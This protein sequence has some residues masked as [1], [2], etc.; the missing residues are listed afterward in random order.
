MKAILEQISAL[1]VS[2]GICLLHNRNTPKF[3]HE[4]I[5][6]LRL[7]FSQFGEDI[8]LEKWFY[9]FFQI[10]NGIYVDAGAYHPIHYSNT[11]AQERLARSEH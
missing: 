6:Y 7:S 9:E 8:G 10:E 5:R 4:E 1:L 11:L 2:A 3:S